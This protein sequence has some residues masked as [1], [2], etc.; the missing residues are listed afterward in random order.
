MVTLCSRRYLLGLTLFGSLVSQSPRSEAAAHDLQSLEASPQTPCGPQL[1]RPV[2]TGAF[3]TGL[4]ARLTS[5]SAKIEATA[6]G[7]L[8]ELDGCLHKDLKAI[9]DDL[10]RLLNDDPVINRP[11]IVALLM[12]TGDFGLTVPVGPGVEAVRQAAEDYANF[13]IGRNRISTYG[14]PYNGR[15]AI[16][17]L[18]ELTVGKPSAKERFAVDRLYSLSGDLK[19]LRGLEAD[20]EAVSR[21]GN[22][23]NAETESAF[24]A[25]RP[26]LTGPAAVKAALGR[27][28]AYIFDLANP[29]PSQ[30]RG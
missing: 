23:A 10:E 12:R 8:M 22:L 19:G 5:E 1:R 29:K 2:A 13:L 17:A 30:P 7:L 15:H 26:A 18:L 4:R 3:L 27:I 24:L 21:L 16:H 14:T 28:Q 9:V 25:Q 6:E 20:I 11:E